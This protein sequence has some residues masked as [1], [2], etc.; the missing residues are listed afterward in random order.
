[1]L[2]CEGLR[3]TVFQELRFAKSNLLRY[4]GVPQG[5]MLSPL[6]FTL[7]DNNWGGRVTMSTFECVL[8]MLL[9]TRFRI[10]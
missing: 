7:Y 1:M 2:I 3:N 5:S 10:S 8:I 4:I 9:Y 6:M